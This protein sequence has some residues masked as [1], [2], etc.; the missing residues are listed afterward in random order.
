MV[1]LTRQTLDFTFCSTI[2][3]EVEFTAHAIFRVLT[4]LAHHDDRRLDGRKHGEKQ[5]EQ[6]EWI[7]I[8]GASA[9]RD[10]QRGINNENGQKGKDES[11]GSTKTSHDIRDSFAEGSFPLNDL[12][13]IAHGAQ[14]HQLLGCVKLPA[15]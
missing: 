4:I 7:G 12:V 1:H 2:D 14:S 8:P 13:G 10:L 6:N 11:P 3:V 5:V 9:E 15:E